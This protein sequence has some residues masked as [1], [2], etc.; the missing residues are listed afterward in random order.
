ME[1]ALQSFATQVLSQVVAPIIGTL[2]IVLLALELLCVF[3]R[4]RAI[5]CVAA[6]GAALTWLGWMANI[7]RVA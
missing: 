7:Y 1:Q 4:N 2:V 6:Y 5:R 3:V